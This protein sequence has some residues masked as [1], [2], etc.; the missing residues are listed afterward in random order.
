MDIFTQFETPRDLHSAARHLF[1]QALDPYIDTIMK[2]EED[3]LP[4]LFLLSYFHGM[5]AHPHDHELMLAAATDYAEQSGLGQ[6]DCTDCP[7]KDEC[8]DSR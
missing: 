4:V 2:N 5:E 6:R 1:I 3:L 8:D 7:K